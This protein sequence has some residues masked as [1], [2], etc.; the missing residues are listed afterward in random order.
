M[1]S[2]LCVV[3]IAWLVLAG[4]ASAQ[5]LLLTRTSS[6]ATYTAAGQVITYTY[7]V[8]NN[9]SAFS[10][11][12]LI[13]T[14]DDKVTTINC[15]TTMLNAMS[16]ITCTGTYTITA[17]DVI[18]GFVTN[19]ASFAADICNDSC[20]RSAIAQATVTFAAPPNPSWTLSKTPNPTTYTAAGQVISYSFLLTNT[21]NVAISA[22]SISD[23][24][25][26]T[27]T[28]PATT[29][30]VGANMTCTGS[31]TTT[32]ADV[33][34]GSVTNTATASGTPAA[35][36]LPNAT[37]QA[38]ITRT[39]Q[40]SWTLTKTPNPATYT[41]AGQ[42]INY[43]FV[44]RNTGNV[45]ISAIS[46]SD[47]RI[48]T[49][50]CPATT[51]AIGANM[52]CTG[53]YTTTAADVTA[54]SVTNTATATGTPASGTLSPATAQVTITR[55]AQP[56]WTL[57]KTPNPTT[58][59]AAGQVINYSFVLRNSGNVAISAIS[60][61]DNRIA[62]VTCPAT[63]LAIGANMTCTGSYTT[64]VADV[65][66]GSVTNTATA[67]GTPAAGSLPNATAQATITRTAQPSWTLTKTATPSTYSAAAQNITY[68]Y[69]LRNTGNVSIS[70]ISI[71]DN[72]VA[73]IEC[74]V[75]TLAVG[76]NM[77]CTGTYTTTAAD[78]TAR[79]RGQHRDRDRDPGRR[80]PCRMPPRKPPSRCK[81]SLRGR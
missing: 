39:A 4:Q 41:A 10:E 77:T 71:S 2:T 43:N 32:A 19:N 25:I 22:I 26:A 45:A 65:T 67:S 59:T 5:D 33:T 63:T 13:S 34:A 70:A 53:S 57:T 18:A 79:K 51:L 23:N 40:P 50:T 80:H 30:A 9:Q 7:V 81:R 73:G 24:R 8:T 3:V 55:T 52:T 35:G 29:L 28:C 54:G 21:G 20:L 75:T 47:N 27:V 64:T 46:I 1:A 48:A 17:A 15:P 62:S 61:S 78:V 69:V 42:V 76:A 68:R 72:R 31:Y 56:S 14:F 44:L 38:T 60:I 11:G 16:S 37:A 58:Y 49:V 36:S 12:T 74:P 6:P 66:A